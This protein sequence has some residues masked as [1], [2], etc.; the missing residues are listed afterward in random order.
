MEDPLQAFRSGFLS[1][2]PAGRVLLHPS[3]AEAARL[4]L[5]AMDAADPDGALRKRGEFTQSFRMA[6]GRV[7]PNG[8]IRYEE[9]DGIDR[10]IEPPGTLISMHSH[11]D[12]P[13]GLR[14][15]FPSPADYLI[16]RVMKKEVGQVRELVYHAP[17]G[18]FYAFA[19]ELPPT[20]RLALIPPPAPDGAGE[21]KT[22]GPSAGWI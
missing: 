7:V 2:R 6:D 22:A 18:N 20:F 3:E 21:P 19:G 15:D 4:F 5:R 1:T 10:P 12:P 11:P 13:Q 14:N 16:A 9:G 8:S 17:S